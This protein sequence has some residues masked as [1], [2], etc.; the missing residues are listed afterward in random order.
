MGTMDEVSR[1]ISEHKSE[2]LEKFNIVSVG[3]FGSY[4]RGEQ[5]KDSDIDLLVELKEDISLLRLV[6]AENFLSDLL[7]RKVDLVPKDD[8]RPELRER[9]LREVVYI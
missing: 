9:I 5:H 6:S 3:V 2:L 7:R 1:I 8:V 4:V